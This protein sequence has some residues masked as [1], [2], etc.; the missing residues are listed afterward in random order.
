MNN[1]DLSKQVSDDELKHI[2]LSNIIKYGDLN[3]YGSLLDLLP[4]VGS[5]VIILIESKYNRGHWT[6]MI[7]KS[8]NL[9]YY[10]DS[11]GQGVDGELKFIAPEE[12]RRLGEDQN[13]LSRLISQLPKSIKVISNS[14]DYQKD[15]PEIST[16]GRHV[17]F[18]LM[19]VLKHGLTLED[20]HKLIKTGM[21]KTGLDSD[22]LICMLTNQ[23]L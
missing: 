15:S 7:R 5:Y 18:F 4:D 17:M 19:S 10:F 13:I 16:C 21:I 9:I 20:Y 6:C 12:R 14:I 8:K 1:C 22:H 23:Y 2:G 11:Y 3:R